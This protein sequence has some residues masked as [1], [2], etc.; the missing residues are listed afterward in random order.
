MNHRT[1]SITAD[2]PCLDGHFP[3]API[4]PGVVV[5]DRVIEQVQAGNAGLVT[6]IRRC[7]FLSAL[8]PGEPCTIEWTTAANSA[9]FVCRGQNSVVA[10]GTLSL[11]D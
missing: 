2:D 8:Y 9:R 11:A 10:E 5:L 3:D 7:K 4:V 1:F 6:G